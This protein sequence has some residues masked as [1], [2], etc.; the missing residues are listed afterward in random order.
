MFIITWDEWGENAKKLHNIWR[1]R[2]FQLDDL[3]FLFLLFMMKYTEKTKTMGITTTRQAVIHVFQ[4]NVIISFIGLRF[5][6]TAL[7][8]PFQKVVG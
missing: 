4:G 6:I 2:A 7:T 1:H 3:V 5:Y 8:H